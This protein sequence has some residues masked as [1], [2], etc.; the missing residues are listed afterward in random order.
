MPVK[1][2]FS[3]NPN[4]G[5][6]RENNWILLCLAADGALSDKLV[7]FGE[8]RQLAYDHKIIFF[9]FSLYLISEFK[10]KKEK[11]NRECENCTN[12]FK[13]NM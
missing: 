7:N 11:Y 2:A 10:F 12:V 4:F 9:L 1:Q 6:W 13:I 8:K 5:K 3:R